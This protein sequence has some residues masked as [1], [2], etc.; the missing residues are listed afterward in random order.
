MC[1]NEVIMDALSN[2]TIRGE[3][4]T[5]LQFIFLTAALEDIELSVCWLSSKE[6]WI[7][8]ALLHFKL[9]DIANLGLQISIQELH[10][11]VQLLRQ[12]LASFFPTALPD[13]PDWPMRLPGLGIGSSLSLMA[14]Q[15]YQ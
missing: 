15:P 14:T 4:I 6:N 11:P 12:W 7:A 3:A 2:M 8:D 9:D 5:V 13:L 1:D 10:D